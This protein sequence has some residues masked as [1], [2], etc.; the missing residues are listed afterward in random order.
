M[1]SILKGKDFRFD[2]GGA[3]LTEGRVK[4]ELAGGYFFVELQVGVVKIGRIFHL[5][6]MNA[7]EWEF[8]IGEGF[9]S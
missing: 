9:S 4:K 2:N 3:V 7:F 1:A 8:D 5:S 6:D